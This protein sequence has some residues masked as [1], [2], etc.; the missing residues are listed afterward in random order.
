MKVV[1]CKT[2]CD[3]VGM[4][5]SA[6]SATR[7]AIH[8]L[9]QRTGGKGGLIAVDRRAQV[10]IAFNTDAMPH[11]WQSAMKISASAVNKHGGYMDI[12][13]ITL[14]TI[15]DWLA[16]LACALSLPRSY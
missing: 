15:V 6:E 10:G 2:A 16:A 14:D 12:S 3:F 11:A 7:A 8:L 13:Q 5:L 9:E 1:I 4:G